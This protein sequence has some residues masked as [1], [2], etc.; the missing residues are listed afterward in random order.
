[1]SNARQNILDRIQALNL[2]AVPLPT[3]PDFEIGKDLCGKFGLAIRK[4]KGEMASEEEVEL[5]LSD[6][7]PEYIF[8]TDL[9]FQGFSKY[10]LPK[11]PKDL[12]NLEVAILSGAFGVAENGAMWLPDSLL[13]FRVMPFI[14]QHLIITLSK[15]DL[16]G[17]MH[18]A[19]RRI[20]SEENSF[21][22][23]MAGPSK[24]ADI[25]QSLV[26]GAHGAKSLRVVLR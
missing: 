14:T 6:Y 16:V 21:G 11:Q 23:L 10:Q 3:I 20:G 15:N 4:N 26:V 25:E 1:M 5:F 7:R 17:N 13:P 19:Y 22:L 24:T 2:P 8:S 12:D 18:E 9:H